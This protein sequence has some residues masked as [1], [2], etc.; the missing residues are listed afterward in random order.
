VTAADFAH[1]VEVHQDRGLTGAANGYDLIEDVE[2]IDD[3][4]FLLSL[5]APFGAW[6]SLF[7]R[8]YPDGESLGDIIELPT[9]GPFDFVEWTEGDHVTIARDPERWAANDPISGERPGNVE[10]VTF[11]FIDTLEEMVDALEAGEV[12]VVSARP[13]E[14]SVERLAGMEDAV[15]ELAPGP[16]WEHIDFHHDHPLLSQRWVREAIST[17]I[18]RDKILDRTVRLLDPT[19]APLDNTVFMTN[20]ANYEAHF[21][22]THDPG[23]AERILAD[24]GCARGED[25]IF[26]CDDTRMSFTWASTNDDPART[27]IFGSV[28]EDLAAVGIEIV[29]DMRSP[30]EFVT[31]DFLFGNPDVWQLINFSWRAR[32]EPMAANTTYYC[33]SSGDLN[34][35]RYCSEEVEGLIRATETIAGPQDRVDAY[36][37]ADRLYLDDIAVIPLYQKPILMAWSNELSGPQPNYT[38]S[39]D[40]WNVA[41]W[42]GEEEVVVALPVEPTELNPLSRSDESANVILGALLYGAFGMNP[43]HEYVPVLVDSVEIIEGRE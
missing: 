4:T 17:A 18:D 12:D 28:R 29:A 37:R 34:V 38:Y 7:D 35:N 3:K 26:V 1:T 24:H 31:R 9:S 39:A 11:V 32:P 40:F 21:D 16:F 14:Q 30:S 41:S 33:D 42:S 23:Q 43:A 15:F 2:I 19:A 27:E 22:D 10:Q 5:S 8:I 6:Q 20:T 25:G 13:D 36:N